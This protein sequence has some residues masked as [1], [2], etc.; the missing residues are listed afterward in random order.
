MMRARGFAPLCVLAAL[1][2]G[3]TSGSG[4]AP[5]SNVAEQ[6]FFDKYAAA[7]CDGLAKCCQQQGTPIDATQ[8]KQT[9]AALAGFLGQGNHTFN[10][11]AANQCLKDAQNAV[12]QCSAPSNGSNACDDV[13]VGNSP[14]GGECR[15]SADCKPPASGDH[16]CLYSQG[17]QTG[18]CVA[19]PTPAAGQPCG[20]SAE[21]DTVW[22]RCDEADDLY[23]D[24]EAK[25]C[26]ARV[27]VGASC[28]SSA[29][30]VK[31]A[32]CDFSS[33]ACAPLVALGGDCSQTGC[34]DAAY[35]DAATCVAKKQDGAPCQSY[36]ECIGY[37][38]STAGTCT[39]GASSSGLDCTL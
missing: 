17:S 8:C 32:S 38:D 30:C 14:P 36:D 12:N 3:C 11:A 16:T 34:V 9:I 19:E 24:Y 39:G 37:C 28:S 1:W 6:D 31:D 18:R 15:T 29:E 20:D 5:S 22:Y 23:C 26:K 10:S 7:V 27:P 2:S 4:S 21:T 35:C 25:V 13:W 33:S